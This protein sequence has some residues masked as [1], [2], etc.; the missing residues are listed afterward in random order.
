[1]HVAAGNARDLGMA[2]DNIFHL[3]GIDEAMLVHEADATGEGR[4]M[5][6]DQGRAFGR[7]RQGVLE[8]LQALG[9]HLPAV[10]A[11]AFGV[12]SDQPQG[13][14][15]QH[16]VQ[17]RAV[18]GQVTQIAEV[19][20]YHVA[21]VVIA[22]ND[23]DRH[24]QAL[25]FTAH[26]FII[27][28]VGLVDQIA[29]RQHQI[30]PGGKAVEMLNGRVQ[31]GNGIDLAFQQATVGT[32][33]QVGNLS[34]NHGIDH[35]ILMARRS[36][37]L[38]ITSGTSELKRKRLEV[39]KLAANLTWLFTEVEFLERFEAAAGVAF[40]GV[41]FLFP[42]D[43][44]ASEVLGRL[45]DNNLEAVLINAPPGDWEA[46]ERGLGCVADRQ[47]DFRDS[48]RRAIDY[49]L[50]IDCPN[51]H[52]MAGIAD[53]EAKNLF[54]ENLHFAAAACATAGLTGLIEPINDMDM[55]GYFL[56]R[57]D[58]ALEIIKA[59][60][61]PA[62]GLQLD[63]YHTVRMGLDPNHVID[64][65]KNAIAHIQIAG[66]PGRHEPDIGEVDFLAIFDRIDALGYDGWVG[67]EY[68][69]R[70]S[71]V[72]GLGWASRYLVVS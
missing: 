37:Q 11:V 68:R 41:E 36:V 4:V 6:E 18:A 43:F 72:A 39:P 19:L 46:G 53:T 55:P 9:A 44:K 67:C 66:V 22:G 26:D 38:D 28:L 51:I 2:L 29:G 60:G 10:M 25:E 12:Q 56:T 33:V 52:I 58:Q 5:H 35:S 27:L 45:A 62:L 42:Y 1:M 70:I 49:A 13:V 50:A 30:G 40:R 3:P 31:G 71:S 61:S 7:C 59:V 14:I 54:I 65:C 32:Q 15:F 20:P 8:P 23:E 21:V 63:I 47:E 57:P 16:V 34:D 48:V 69:P 64:V 24:F 17:E